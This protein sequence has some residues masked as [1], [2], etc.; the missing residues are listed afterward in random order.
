MWK[1]IKTQPR[2]WISHIQII[3]MYIQAKFEISLFIVGA[4]AVKAYIVGILCLCNAFPDKKWKYIH[5][6]SFPVCL[7]SYD[8]RGNVYK[9]VFL[10]KF[11]ILP[12]KLPDILN[13]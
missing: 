10:L 3:Y 4:L 9:K 13:L 1:Q 2:P 6:C 12:I 11:S 5:K 8:L 7:C